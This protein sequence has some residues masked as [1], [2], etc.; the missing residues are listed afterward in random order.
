MLF[1][2][3]LLP[4]FVLPLGLVVALLLIGLVRRR[5]GP[6]LAALV[7]LYL[8]STGYVGNGLF[9]LLET[10]YPQ[11]S[12][13]GVGQADAI[14]P[15]GGM[16]GPARPP[17]CASC[18]ANLNEANERLEAGIELWRRGKAPYLVFTGGRVPWARQAE[19][20]GVAVARLAQ[21]RGVPSDRILVTGEVGNTDDEA[22]AL[23]ALMR[24]RDWHRIILVTSAWHMPRA[25][26]LFRR[27]GVGFIPFPVDYQ[28][29]PGVPLTILDFLPRAEALVK[30]EQALRELYGMAYY[31]VRGR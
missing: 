23:A 4:V 3:K 13:D 1:L 30:T 27:V 26:R 28:V 5:R 25:A 21:A 17:G 8:S 16:L 7:L 24:A 9:Q 20:E 11:L 2:A 19:P 15:L 10:R 14:V 31:R 6:A 29:D 18:L 22:H 12:L